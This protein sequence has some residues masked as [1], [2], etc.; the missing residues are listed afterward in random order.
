MTA[1]ALESC[2]CFFS[3]D[4]SVALVISEVLSECDFTRECGL[5]AMHCG[6]SSGTVF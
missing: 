4:R 1:C 5:E 6:A 3:D 2:V